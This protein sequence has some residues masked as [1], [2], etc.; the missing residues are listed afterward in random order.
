MPPPDNDYFIDLKEVLSMLV[1]YVRVST[2]D[3]NTA[4]QEVLM[5]TLGVTKVF[6]DHASGKNTARPE[7]QKM[8][9]FVREGDTVIVESYSRLARSTRDL[10]DIVEVLKEKGVEFI[11][12]KESIDTSTP[13]GKMMLTFFAAIAEF[14]REVL[15]ERQREGIREA[16][17]N[18]AYR[19][20]QKKAMD[21][22]RFAALY[23]EWKAGKMQAVAFQKAM[24]LNPRTF[25]RRVQAYEAQK[26]AAPQ[27]TVTA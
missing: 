20:R 19:G 4:R 5:E 24:K 13:A 26:G 7:L 17:K 1:G 11:S 6:V 27:S 9:A 22:E 18:G 3:Q 25:Y 10:L 2:D 16:K 21:E 8:L 14:E 12:R 15:L 23:T